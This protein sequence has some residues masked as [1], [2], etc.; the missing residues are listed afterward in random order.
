LGTDYETP[1]EGSSTAAAAAAASGTVMLSS[2]AADGCELRGAGWRASASEGLTY[3]EQLDGGAER[4]YRQSRRRYAHGRVAQKRAS[5]V[6]EV[7]EALQP[8]EQQPGAGPAA[9]HKT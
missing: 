2:T 5:N 6:A 7:A 3:G 9:H 1:R 8:A 4:G